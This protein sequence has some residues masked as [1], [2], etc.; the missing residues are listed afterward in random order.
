[1]GVGLAHARWPGP[2]TGS[3]SGSGMSCRTA[4]RKLILV[5]NNGRP[6][7]NCG[8]RQRCG[9]DD[10][11][12]DQSNGSSIDGQRWLSS[13]RLLLCSGRCHSLT[14]DTHLPSLPAI[15]VMSFAI[16]TRSHSPLSPPRATATHLCA[17]S[18]FRIALDLSLVAAEITT[19][20]SP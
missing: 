13:A 20:V 2:V 14:D 10:S 16:I 9:D 15:H 4:A 6:G 7:R 1:M 11:S 12:S 19:K 17:V 8:G 3:D 5:R 18:L